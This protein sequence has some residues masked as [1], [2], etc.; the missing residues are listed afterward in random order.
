LELLDEIEHA[1]VLSLVHSNL[2]NTQA[3]IYP[4]IAPWSVMHLAVYRQLS[5]LSTASSKR[6]FEK[7]S[8][9]WLLFYATLLL[10]YHRAYKYK[11]MQIMVNAGTKV[12]A[13]KRSKIH[14]SPAT[15]IKPWLKLASSSSTKTKMTKMMDSCRLTSG[16]GVRFKLIYRSYRIYRSSFINI[17]QCDSPDRWYKYD[18]FEN[19]NSAENKFFSCAGFLS[20]SYCQMKNCPKEKTDNW[21]CRGETFWIYADYKTIN[22]YTVVNI[23]YSTSGSRG[24][25]VSSG[26]YKCG[27]KSLPNTMGI[28]TKTRTCPGKS[29]THIKSGCDWENFRIWKWETPTSIA[30]F[31]GSFVQLGEEEYV[32]ELYIDGSEIS[33]TGHISAP[34]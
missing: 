32:Y 1:G 22:H 31:D 14:K 7:K 23:L 6:A 28:K 9:K 15:L 5:V 2:E 8:D 27:T 29:F 3:A 11:M 16:D 24:Y 17:Y 12:P 21:A 33:K 20:G 10:R 18:A 13:V 30:I 19:K 34:F 25:W 4:F 26:N